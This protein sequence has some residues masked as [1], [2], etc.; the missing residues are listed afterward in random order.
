MG[1]QTPYGLKSRASVGGARVQSRARE[2]ASSIRYPSMA[3]ATEGP[4][5]AKRPRLEDE[6]GKCL[7]LA[8][9]QKLAAG[10]TEVV[11]ESQAAYK[12]APNLQDYINFRNEFGVRRTFRA[13]PMYVECMSSLGVSTRRELE[14]L[15]KAHFKDEGVREKVDELIHVE[16]SFDEFLAEVDEELKRDEAQLLA[17]H[18][19]EDREKL[20]LDVALVDARSGGTIK[21][22]SLCDKEDN[23][24]LTLLILMRHFG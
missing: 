10:V 11:E 24:H 21:L 6:G 15:W 8:A 14:E 3:D 7:L 20:P 12:A 4:G 2:L 17:P 9:L 16:E 19:V 13:M 18:V 5:L 23:S 22:E 1:S